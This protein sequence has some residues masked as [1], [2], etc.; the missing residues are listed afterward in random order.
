MYVKK[1]KLFEEIKGENYRYY[2][3][4][5]FEEP[6]KVEH[7]KALYILPITINKMKKYIDHYK[8][9]P[10]IREFTV[11]IIQT[12]PTK[13]Q[14]K[15]VRRI[16]NWIKDNIYYVSDI[17]GVET[18]QSPIQT[19]INKWGDCDCQTTLIG[20]MLAS[21]GIPIRIIIVN[22]RPFGDYNHTYIE[23][24]VNGGWWALDTTNK[25]GKV[26]WS[27]KHYKKKNIR[28]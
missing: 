21:V 18:L 25:K 26:G 27:V 24:F 1:Q 28:V 13:N 14:L 6:Y 17:Y 15:K 2:N 11:K 10:Q 4:I 19:L 7:F 8:R 20:S 23:A 22:T 9:L 3:N 16:F 12:E 5:K